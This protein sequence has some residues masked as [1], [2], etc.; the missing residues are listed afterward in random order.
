MD[1]QTRL[2]EAKERL[3][4]AAQACLENRAGAAE[5]ANAAQAEVTTLLALQRAQGG[6]QCKAP[7]CGCLTFRGLCDL[8]RPPDVWTEVRNVL[9]ELNQGEHHDRRTHP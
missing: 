6:Q 5:Q 7:G 8:H 4:R 9:D 1:L 2:I 3:S